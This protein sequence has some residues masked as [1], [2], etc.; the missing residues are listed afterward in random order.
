M[1]PRD[2][3]RA[4]HVRH[5]LLRLAK[6]GVSNPK[7]SKKV[8]FLG[9]L[10]FAVNL[11]RLVEPLDSRACITASGFEHAEIRKRVSFG[12]AVIT[13]MCSIGKRFELRS[14]LV[15]LSG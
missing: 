13:A 2:P 3:Q 1:R 6:D 15:E 7:L 5:R 9:G 12:R 8:F 11:S 10:W 4:V 14:R